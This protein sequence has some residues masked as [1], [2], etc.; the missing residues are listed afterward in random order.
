MQDVQN[1]CV[2][3]IANTIPIG[4]EFSEFTRRSVPHLTVL[5]NPNGFRQHERK[6][7][8]PIIAAVMPEVV[9][10]QQAATVLL[11]SRHGF[12]RSSEIKVHPQAELAIPTESIPKQP[13]FD[14]SDLPPL[15]FEAA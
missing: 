11:P 3:V 10:I 1:T 14:L 8:A 6:L 9:P 15:E 4:Q 12:S 7:L 2:D 13:F 5:H